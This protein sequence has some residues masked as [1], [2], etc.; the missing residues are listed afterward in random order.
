MTWAFG[1]GVCLLLVRNGLF[2][3]AGLLVREVGS[4]HVFTGE[5][6]D[7]ENFRNWKK[8]SGFLSHS[9]LG[10]CSPPIIFRPVCVGFAVVRAVTHF[11]RFCSDRPKICA[12]LLGI[13][14]FLIIFVKLV[15]VR[16]GCYTG[17]RINLINLKQ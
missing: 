9:F 6:Q 5:D 12:E 2:R 4:A 13:F 14:L 7:S 3:S 11:R 16:R 1:F 8:V 10:A 15:S 17:Q